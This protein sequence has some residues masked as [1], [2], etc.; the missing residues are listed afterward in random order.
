MILS[1]PETIKQFLGVLG[2][3]AVNFSYLLY[4]MS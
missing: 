3:M 4:P 1:Y 2:V